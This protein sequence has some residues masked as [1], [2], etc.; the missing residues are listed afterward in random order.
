MGTGDGLKAT[1]AQRL[2]AEGPRCPSTKYKAVGGRETSA[3]DHVIPAYA[4][5]NG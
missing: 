5:L 1:G 3:N 4:H 2:C